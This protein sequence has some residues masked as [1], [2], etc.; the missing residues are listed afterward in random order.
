VREAIVLCLED[1]V[2]RDRVTIDR[3][4][5]CLDRLAQR[6]RPGELVEPLQQYAAMTMAS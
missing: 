6:A 5:L 3:R 2:E 1:R 4:D